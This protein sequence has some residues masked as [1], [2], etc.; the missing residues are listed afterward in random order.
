MTDSDL[1]C[2]LLTDYDECTQLS[3]CNGANEVCNNTVGSYKCS[4]ESGYARNSSNGVCEGQND[5]TTNLY[6]LPSNFKANTS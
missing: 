6:I 5:L 3:P 2:P 1:N 4:C